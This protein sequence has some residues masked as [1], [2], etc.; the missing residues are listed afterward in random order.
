MTEVMRKACGSKETWPCHTAAF[1]KKKR[2][3]NDMAKMAVVCVWCFKV[4]LTQEFQIRI[5]QAIL[6]ETV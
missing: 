5:L 6:T 1:C 3:K 4:M 2:G